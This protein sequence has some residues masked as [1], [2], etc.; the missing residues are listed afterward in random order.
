MGK[1]VS[2]SVCLSMEWGGAANGVQHDSYCLCPQMH[3]VLA[4]V[5]IFTGGRRHI[6]LLCVYM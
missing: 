1:L 5:L 2:V 4:C 3:I 6:Y